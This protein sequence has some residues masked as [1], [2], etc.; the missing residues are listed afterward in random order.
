LT[1]RFRSLMIG[2]TRRFTLPILL[3][4]RTK[5]GRQTPLQNRFPRIDNG[6]NIQSRRLT[7]LT[8]STKSMAMGTTKLD[9]NCTTTEGVRTCNLANRTGVNLTATEV[10]EGADPEVACEDNVDRYQS[11]EITKWHRQY[12]LAPG[13]DGEPSNDT[14]PSFTIGNMANNGSF[15]CTTSTVQEDAFEGSC[16]SSTGASDT[17]AKFRFVSD[18]G[19]LT[20]TQSWTCDNS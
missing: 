13:S 5:L 3:T 20:L 12:E 8:S 2:V 7:D 19:M 14:G 17:T 6:L 11:W 18:I 4:V 9:L 16:T 10:S 15:E 1:G